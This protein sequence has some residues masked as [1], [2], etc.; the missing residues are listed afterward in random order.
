[1][2]LPSLLW[3]CACPSGGGSWRLFWLTTQALVQCRSKFSSLLLLTNLRPKSIILLVLLSLPPRQ[4]R[5]Q[6]EAMRKAAAQKMQMEDLRGRVLR[7]RGPQGT[8][9]HLP[10]IGATEQIPMAAY[11]VACDA[12]ARGQWHLSAINAVPNL[13][14]LEWQT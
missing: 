4:A 14:G 11:P 2:C 3:C 6:A 8:E 1:M 10:I 9:C 5:I 13:L 7:R 12:G